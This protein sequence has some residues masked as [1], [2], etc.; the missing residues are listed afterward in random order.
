MPFFLKKT[1]LI[2]NTNSKKIHFKFFFTTVSL[3]HFNQ[4]SFLTLYK[5]FFNTLLVLHE[6]YYKIHSIAIIY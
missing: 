6:I 5:L 4:N 2:I 1:H 3:L